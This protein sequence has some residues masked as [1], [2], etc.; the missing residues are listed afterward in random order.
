MSAT[1]QPIRPNGRALFFGA[2]AATARP[3]RRVTVSQWADANRMLTSKASSEVGQWKTSRTPFAREAAIEIRR[4]THEAHCLAV[5]L[6]IADRRSDEHY[7]DSLVPCGF[8][9]YRKF[10]KRA[11]ATV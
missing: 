6:G 2:V 10:Y 7:Q 3:R 5:E 11:P 4:L 8:G 1:A 9:N